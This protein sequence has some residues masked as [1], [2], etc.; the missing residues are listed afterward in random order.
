MR[1]LLDILGGIG[2]AAVALVLGVGIGV[3]EELGRLVAT[4]QKHP[5]R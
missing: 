4:W 3:F 1:D 5:R 2:D